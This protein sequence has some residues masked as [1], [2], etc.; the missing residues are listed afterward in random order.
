[1]SGRIDYKQKYQELKNRF[2][3]SI[4]SAW[5]DGFENGTSTSPT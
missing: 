4:D 2:M 5:R 3:S 1:M